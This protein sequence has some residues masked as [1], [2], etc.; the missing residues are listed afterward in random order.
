MWGDVGSLKVIELLLGFGFSFGLGPMCLALSLT[1]RL[2]V[3]LTR[4]REVIWG[5]MGR[6]GAIWGGMGRYG[7][8]YRALDEE[9]GE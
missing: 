7:E 6:Y 8:V 4:R 1:V 3:R 5:D 9:E 2:T